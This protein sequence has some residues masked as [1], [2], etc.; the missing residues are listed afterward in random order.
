MTVRITKPEIN[1]REKL[2]ELDYGKVPYHKMPA[3]SVIQVVDKLFTPTA[4]VTTT[5]L[6]Y[7]DMGDPFNLSIS[8][9]LSNSKILIDIMLNPYIA[10]NGATGTYNIHNGSS[11]LGGAAN[12][13]GMVPSSGGTNGQYRHFNI[14]ASDTASS[15][16]TITYRIYH[17]TANSGVTF[18]GNHATFTNYIRLTEIAQ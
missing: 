2:A 10:G 14:N 8:P 9:K 3:G 11:Q 13:F 7:V 15:T 16:S 1:V 5:S 4:H 17:R 12:G 18:Y 6:T